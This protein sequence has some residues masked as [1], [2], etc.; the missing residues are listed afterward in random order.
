MQMSLFPLSGLEG[1]RAKTSQL[2]EWARA[3]GYGGRALA[4]LMSLFGWLSEDAPQF[5]LS[6][7]FQASSLP[8]KGETS[9]SLFKL[10]PTSGMAWGGV[11]LTA[12]TSESPSHV[13]ES[14]LLDVIETGVVP[15]RYF[16]SPNAAKG[17]LRRT[18]R[19]G[20]NLFPPLRESLEIL[21]K[22]R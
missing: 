5:L 12:K 15:D 10:W 14:T 22:D 17:M 18:D 1:F 11:C 3:K 7:T 8:T 4:S 16:L 13:E 21:A 19:M 9:S 6:K 20:R 2:R